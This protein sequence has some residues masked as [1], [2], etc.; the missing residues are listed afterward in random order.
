MKIKV[1]ST[2]YK[3]G[4]LVIPGTVTDLNI[5]FCQFLE[6]LVLKPGITSVDDWAFAYCYSLSQ[7]EIPET[8]TWIGEYAFYHSRLASVTIP[9]SVTSISSMAFSE[10]N[11]EDVYYQGTEAEWNTIAGFPEKHDKEY[12]S[13][14]IH[15]LEEFTPSVSYQAKVVGQSKWQSA[16][17]D[18]KEAGTTGKSL[19]M[20]AFKINIKDASTGKNA[21]TDELGVEYSGHVQ[22]VGWENWVSNGTAAGRPNKSLRIEALKIRLTGRLA[23]KY[24]I[25]Y[26]LHC[27]NYG[28]LGWAKNGAE[29]G[30]AGMGLRVEAVRIQILAKGSTAPAKPG[31]YAKA[32]MFSPELKYSSY[33]QDQGWQNEVK[34]NAISGTLGKS[35]RLEG[36][37]IRVE[38]EKKLGVRYKGHVQNVGWMDWV[39][40]GAVCGQPGKNRRIEALQLELTGTDSSKY[41]IYYCLHVQNFGWL[42]WAKN[43]EKAGSSGVSM[44]VEGYAVKILPKG[45]PV[46]KNWGSKTQ[47]FIDGIGASK[48]TLNM[49]KASVKPGKTVTLKATVIP[50]NRT[51]KGVT[52]TSSNPEVAAVSG[53]IITAKKKGTAAI[54]C[55]S[56]DGRAY[57]V[58]RITVA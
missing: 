20:E 36:F 22:N 58:C 55:T 19:I 51:F 32:Y 53:G 47:A 16:V 28:W 13:I 30:T 18:G 54:T 42:A 29:A 45:S 5:G 39:S 40:D 27:Q 43:G 35:L 57:A 41:D 1:L 46:P 8:V 37:K 2:K 24:D 33:V 9:K 50:A 14:R 44:R 21:D 34:K 10:G 38:G 49:S 17:K 23:D 25:Y 56:N 31:S 52:W 6:K 15:F 3:A 12:D 48:L 26:C 4:M 7:V 11:V